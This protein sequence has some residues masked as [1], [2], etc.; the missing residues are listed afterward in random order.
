[1]ENWEIRQ[2]DQPLRQVWGMRCEE[3]EEAVSWIPP[4]G[5]DPSLTSGWR[6]SSAMA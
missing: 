2:R 1:M 6:V 4:Q 5:T 3:E